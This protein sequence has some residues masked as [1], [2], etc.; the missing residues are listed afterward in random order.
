MHI[1]HLIL[2]IRNVVTIEVLW[3][4]I[5][6]RT[7]FGRLDPHAECGSRIQIL[8]DKNDPQ[9]KQETEDMLGSKPGLLRLGIGSQTL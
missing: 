1:Q 5:R 3:I 6:I 2:Q 4:R 8:G 7:D 9:K